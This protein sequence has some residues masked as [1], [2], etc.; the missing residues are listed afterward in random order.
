MK[1]IF[2]LFL[3]FIITISLPYHARAQAD[4]R[5]DNYIQVKNNWEDTARLTKSIQLKFLKKYGL[6]KYGLD[7]IPFKWLPIVHKLQY[8]Q[9]HPYNWN[10]GAMVQAKGWQQF[11]RLGIYAKWKNFEA[12]IAPE[13]VYAENKTF[14]KSV[15][16]RKYFV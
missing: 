14:E 7:S 3:V 10:D 4:L 15:F 16:H 11:T 6:D 13:F 9:D 1:R 12:Q 2:I 8:V 5:Y